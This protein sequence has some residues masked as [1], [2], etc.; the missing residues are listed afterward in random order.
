MKNCGFNGIESP[1]YGFEA[2]CVRVYQMKRCEGLYQL[3]KK[4]GFF[5][6]SQCDAGAGQPVSGK[7]MSDG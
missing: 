3:H 7:V 6:F 5:P 4:I 2:L 1:L